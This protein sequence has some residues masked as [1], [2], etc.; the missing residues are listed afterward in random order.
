M[1]KEGALKM[2][3]NKIYCGDALELMKQL[4]D[5]S[6]DMALTSPP[7][8]G[9]RDYGVEGQLGLEPHPNEYIKKMVEIFQELKRV[10]KKTGS[11][12]LNIGDTYFGGKGKSSFEEEKHLQERIDNQETMQAQHQGLKFNRPPD[13]CKQDGT[14][15]QPKQLMLMP[16]RLAIAMQEAGWILRNDIIWHKPNPMPSSVKDRLNTTYEHIFHFVQSKKYYY[17]LDAIREKHIWADKDKRS[18]L[19]RVEH[20]TSK[21]HGTPLASQAMVGYD[22]RGKNPGDVIQIEPF[23]PEEVPVDLDD[24]RKKG[25]LDIGSY[26]KELDK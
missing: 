17:D 15:L 14:W 4:E 18:K 25:T 7:Y 3:V 22:P 2:E 11:F 12:Y 8:W 10:L 21:Y 26:E 6:V 9:L 23:N 19:V 5:N 20:K 13:I 16:S 1:E 24:F